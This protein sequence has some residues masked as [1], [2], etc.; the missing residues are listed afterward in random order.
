[1]KQSEE[2]EKDGMRYFIE[3]TLEGFMGPYNGR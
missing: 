2:I 3:A 1:M